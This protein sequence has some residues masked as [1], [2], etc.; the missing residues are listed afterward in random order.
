[1]I[2]SGP[3]MNVAVRGGPPG[4]SSSGHAPIL[5]IHAVL[6]FCSIVIGIRTILISILTLV[7]FLYPA[8]IDISQLVGRMAEKPLLPDHFSSEC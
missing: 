3:D 8:L 6:T 1:M 5:E 7:H 4:T 2:A